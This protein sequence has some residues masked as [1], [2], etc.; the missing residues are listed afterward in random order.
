MKA[1]FRRNTS[2]AKAAPTPSAAAS[3]SSPL[4]DRKGQLSSLLSRDHEIICSVKSQW[5]WVLEELCRQMNS[6][7]GESSPRRKLTAVGAVTDLQSGRLVA[8]SPERR[9]ASRRNSNAGGE[10]SDILD[11]SLRRQGRRR[12][13]KSLT[14]P[15]AFV[16]CV[17]VVGTDGGAATSINAFHGN[18]EA[19]DGLE[20]KDEFVRTL[21]HCRCEHLELSPPS[22][23]I[24]WD[25]TKEECRNLVGDALPVLLS[26]AKMTEGEPPSSSAPPRMAVLKEPMGSKGTGIFF[27]KNADE[28]HEI[29]EENR[30][31]AVDEPGFLD[32]LIAQKGRIPS[33]GTL[34]VGI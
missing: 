26:T 27:V 20:D 8:S 23:L 31:K 5:D 28:I 9:A 19:F 25:V 18:S 6:S 13:A 29:I 24:N 14:T 16:L 15:G 1:I 32:Q 22:R 17:E 33:W 3:A 10:N 4:V 30:K 34:L 7:N 21:Q 2:N 12:H 11:R